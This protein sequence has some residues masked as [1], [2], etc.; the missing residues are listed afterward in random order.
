MSS[1]ILNSSSLRKSP[2]LLLQIP[3]IQS[4]SPHFHSSPRAALG[5]RQKALFQDPQTLHPKNRWPL[6]S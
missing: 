2:K 3:Q 6:I 4:K 5:N 1:Q